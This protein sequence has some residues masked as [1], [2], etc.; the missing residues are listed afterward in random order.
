[1]T[2]RDCLIGVRRWLGVLDLGCAVFI[3]AAGY[4]EPPPP[5][6]PQRK[7]LLT[8]VTHWCHTPPPTAAACASVTGPSGPRS[9][10]LGAGLL[11]AG[12]VIAALSCA[13]CA[14]VSKYCLFVNRFW[15]R[16][17]AYLF[18]GVLS[19][20]PAVF[21]RVLFGALVAGIG[22]M[23]L[24]LSLS[25]AECPEPLTGCTLCDT[26]EPVVSAAPPAA[27]NAGKPSAAT[28]RFE[29]ERTATTSGR[30]RQPA[31]GN[32]FLAAGGVPSQFDMV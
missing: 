17:C 28:E 12:A 16:G 14:P 25:T 8:G 18:L 9:F 19:I 21:W 29:E 5:P 30:P 2:V 31:P 1:M 24:L 13:N 27:S 20:D 23:Y 7:F 26:I 11:V 4:G 32:P 6:A 15:G 22:A 3:G 10:F